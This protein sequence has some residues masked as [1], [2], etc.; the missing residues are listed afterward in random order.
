[1]VP[2]AKNLTHSSSCSR[3]CAALKPANAAKFSKEAPG[4]IIFLSF[5]TALPILRTA[6]NGFGVL[7]AATFMDSWTP[8]NNEALRQEEHDRIIGPDGT[9]KAGCKR[10]ISPNSRPDDVE[11]WG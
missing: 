1:M 9:L 10:R 5:P 8:G 6:S 2:L 4:D 11:V 3:S 7:C